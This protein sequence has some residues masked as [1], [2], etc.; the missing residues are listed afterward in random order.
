MDSH[1]KLAYRDVDEGSLIADIR[2]GRFKYEVIFSPAKGNVQIFEYDE[3]DVNCW[4]MDL[5]T[6]EYIEW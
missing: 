3:L 4:E 1:H 5:N 2:V 6:G